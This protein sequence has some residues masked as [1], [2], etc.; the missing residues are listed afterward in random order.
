MSKQQLNAADQG[1]RQLQKDQNDLLLRREALVQEADSIANSENVSGLAANIARNQ[2]ELYAVDQAMAIVDER[3]EQQEQLVFKLGYD[4]AYARLRQFRKKEQQLIK[5]LSK[6][7]DRLEE[8]RKAADDLRL[9]ISQATA[10]YRGG[11]DS[12]LG[13]GSENILSN[14]ARLANSW[15]SQ[16]REF[17]KGYEHYLNSFDVY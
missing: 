10:P 4:E 11:E 8:I 9:K 5:D 12:A 16:G 2:S 1:L 6:E 14:A 17:V 15:A 7:L 13:K 3:I